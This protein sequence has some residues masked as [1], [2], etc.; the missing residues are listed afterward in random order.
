LVPGKVVYNCDPRTPYTEEGSTKSSKSALVMEEE[1]GK[2]RKER[3]EGLR[4]GG[5]EGGKEG[6]RER[7]GGKRKKRKPLGNSLCLPL[8]LLFE[9]L[10]H[11]SQE[12]LNFFVAPSPAPLALGFQVYPHHTQLSVVS[13]MVQGASAHA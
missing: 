2:E 1:D 9:T 10:F 4:E 6:G 8:L 12:G 3:C 5:A 13:W 11:V 7:E